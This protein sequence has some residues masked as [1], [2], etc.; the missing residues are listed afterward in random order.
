[1]ENSND[2]LPISKTCK[3][4]QEI[5]AEIDAE[6]KRLKDAGLPIDPP[7]LSMEELRHWQQVIK[8]EVEKHNRQKELEKKEQE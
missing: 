5:Q 1:M 6:R 8:P 3:S 7:R 4:V 2:D